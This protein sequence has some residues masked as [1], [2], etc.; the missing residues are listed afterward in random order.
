M[1]TPNLLLRQAHLDAQSAVESLWD[2]LLFIDGRL[3][4]PIVVQVRQLRE[5]AILQGYCFAQPADATLFFKM[6]EA[7]A[8]GAPLPEGAQALELTPLPEGYV[9]KEVEPPKRP[10]RSAKKAEAAEGADGAEG[11]E[12]TDGEAEAGD[13]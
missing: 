10:R 3:E 13:E 4:K 8:K 11:A 5:A 12:P 1:T 6:M 9:F 7:Q 2:L